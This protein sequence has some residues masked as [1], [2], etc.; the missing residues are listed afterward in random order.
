MR[1]DDLIIESHHP[2]EPGSA[3]HKAAAREVYELRG[4]EWG[5]DRWSTNY[6][7]NQIRARD[8]N[9]AADDYQKNAGWGIR[10]VTVEVE[11]NGVT[12]NRRLDI[13]DVAAQKAV[14]Y[15]TGYQ[16]AT[17][18][19]I[20]ELQRDAA[21]VREGWSIEWIFRDRASQPLVDALDRAGIK[22]KVGS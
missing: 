20:W 12:S 16:S 10:E 7:M 22:H 14:E 21:L 6:D 13:A 11:I 19:N 17:L 3:E 18:D 2:G 15:K 5:Y 4:G 8:A 9:T 1:L